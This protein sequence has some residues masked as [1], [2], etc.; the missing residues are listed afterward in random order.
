MSF[1]A[2]DCLTISVKDQE[3]ICLIIRDERMMLRLI[4]FLIFKLQTIDGRRDTAIPIIKNLMREEQR[5]VGKFYHFA[6]LEYKR[7]EKKINNYVTMRALFKY[8]LLRV[9]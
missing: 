8:K 3:D 6:S 9:K 2:W 5:K 7:L 1:Y 4:Q